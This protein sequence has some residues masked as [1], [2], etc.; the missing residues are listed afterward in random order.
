MQFICLNHQ[1]LTSNTY[2]L[3]FLDEE[4][5]YG[6]WFVREPDS[7]DD[8][9]CAPRCSTM[10]DLGWNTNRNYRKNTTVI[11]SQ[12]K[13]NTDDTG[14]LNTTGF[15]WETPTRFGA[16]YTDV[17]ALDTGFTTEPRPTL[18]TVATSNGAQ[19]QHAPD[20]GIPLHYRTPLERVAFTGN[21][22][23]QPLQ[24]SF[25]LNMTRT[26]A[27]T[28]YIQQRYTPFEV[29]VQTNSHAFIRTRLQLQKSLLDR[30][31]SVSCEP[32]Q[33]EALR[34][35]NWTWEVRDVL[36]LINILYQYMTDID[37]QRVCVVDKDDNSCSLQEDGN[38][39][40]L[41][42]GNISEV[43]E[44][45]GTSVSDTCDNWHALT[46]EEFKKDAGEDHV[47]LEN[48]DCISSGINHK[49]EESD[50]KN[51]EVSY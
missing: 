27:N 11:C 4:A 8:G 34:R 47:T 7:V 37:H 1:S 19:Q 25:L 29:S 26:S 18:D 17:S 50:L 20:P 51:D 42:A 15:E 12:P 48:D 28:T 2:T 9:A 39:H 14:R 41:T 33:N 10:P 46:E 3:L 31:G 6:A 22:K 38:Q 5:E 43:G 21:M 16:L 24:F 49:P 45:S 44:I 13:S 40:E 36:K 35:I 30:G 23:I 32:C